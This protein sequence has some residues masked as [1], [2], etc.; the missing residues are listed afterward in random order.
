[1]DRPPDVEPVALHGVL[2]V[3]VAFD[4]GDE[5]RLDQAQTLVPAERRTLPRRRRTP[6]SISYSP[7]PLRLL[8]PPPAIEVPELGAAPITAAATVFDF[9]AV[10]VS[11]HVNFH[12]PPDALL[13]LAGHLAQPESWISAACAALKPLYAELLPAIDDPKWNEELSEEYFVFQFAPGEP[14]PVDRNRPDESDWLAGLVRLDAEPLSANEVAEATRHYMTYYPWDLFIADWAGACLI[15]EDCDET[16][17]IIEF[18]NLQLL[19]F[20]HIDNRLDVDLA[21]ASSLI[22]KAVRQRLPI[23][24]GTY[25]SLRAV[26][27]LNVE[28]SNLFE[29][30][31]N[32]LKLV[33]D[34]YLARVYR[35]LANRFHLQNW[36]SNIQRKLE[37]L[38]DVYEVISDQAEA[39]R[40]EFLEVLVV[41][42]III[43]VVVALV[44]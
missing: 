44:R 9:G 43:E 4:W 8:V 37:V 1:M 40:T 19:E 35:L 33:G 5:I 34:Q 15:D 32:V 28:A 42:L 29:R 26:G 31:G 24:R 25:K 14:L 36:E 39:Y 7:P 13:R 22:H 18:V 27:E 2:H 10:S 21:N 6:S 17:Q 30:T 16:L 23:F 3:Y 41:L 38:Q 20:R 11:F 12:A